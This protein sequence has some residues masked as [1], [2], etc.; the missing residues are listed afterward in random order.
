M[1]S[2]MGPLVLSL[3]SSLVRSFIMQNAMWVCPKA[4]MGCVSAAAISCVFMRLIYIQPRL[5][6]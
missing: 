2:S 5:Q 3:K 4:P 6:L 1:T